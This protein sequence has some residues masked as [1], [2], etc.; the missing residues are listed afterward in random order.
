MEERDDSRHGDEVAGPRGPLAGLRVLDFTAFLSGPYGTQM[1]GDLGADVIKLES[2]A[3][4]LSRSIAPHFVRDDSLYYHG[5][6]RNKRSIVINLKHEEAPRLVR[7]LIGTVD[8]VVENFRPG[9]MARLG[10]DPAEIMQEF[11]RL[12]W[13]SLTGFGQ[14]G[15]YK[16]LPAYDMV[17]QAMSGSMSIT[18][19][20]DG[21]PV[22]TGIPLGDLA[23]GLHAVIAVLAA[24]YRRDR[25]GSGEYI[26]ISMLDCLV[27]MLNYQATYYLGSGQVPQPQ[28]R[29]HDSIPTY[30]AFTAKDGRDVVITANTEGMWQALCR[31]LGCEELLDDE[32]FRDNTA[33][34]ANKEALW[35]VLESAFLQASAQEWLDTFNEVGV[36]AALVS[37]FDDVFRDAHVLHRQMVWE[38]TDG[39]G[40]EVKVLGDPIKL[41]RSQRASHRFPPRLGQDTHAVLQELLGITAEQT[42]T[43]E[44]AGMFG[45]G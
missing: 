42:G 32:R 39:D 4:D 44:E 25:Q 40:A 43:W 15:P 5:I 14:T 9:V 21:H 34:L 24:V 30:R 16:S 1:L 12:I 6:N 17:V 7:D 2:P 22:R 3:G 11:P 8:V 45:S 36:P 29:A 13:C 10:L 38:L 26:D 31:A 41:R 37:N 28:G 35:E 23:A 19:E 18:G 27:S 20:P 33:R